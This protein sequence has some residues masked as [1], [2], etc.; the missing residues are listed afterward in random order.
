[1][2]IFDY[3]A[4]S[5]LRGKDI[6]SPDRI[7]LHSKILA[8]K[9]M[10]LDV[11]QMFYDICIQLD[12]QYFIDT[13]GLRVELGAGV[14][15]FNKYYQDVII[16]DIKPAGH[17]NV[18]I[19]AQFMSFKDLSI[20]ALFGINFFHHLPDPN[21]FFQEL[22]RVVH[23]GGGC[24]LIEPYYGPIASMMYKRLF[25]TETFDKKEKL[26]ASNSRGAMIGANQALLHN[27]IIRDK[28]KFLDLYPNLEII[29]VMTISNYI[30][31]IV[32]GGLNFRQLCPNSL[33][34]LLVLSEKIL[35]PLKDF[36]ALH[37]AVVIRKK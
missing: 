19:D 16:T 35:Y 24:V 32:S 12:Q 8:R 22:L 30:R 15:L 37:Y 36:F 29:K 7:E 11:F 1:M 4:E 26:W 31:Y 14:S 27:I 20:H 10:V 6:E 23:T 17:L 9:K 13:P 21:R 3:L 33:E 25:A 28:M 34:R 18:V 5:E 2:S